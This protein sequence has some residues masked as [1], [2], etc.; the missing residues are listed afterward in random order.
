MNGRVVVLA[1]VATALLKLSAL[2]AQ[3]LKELNKAE[4][5]HGTD[6]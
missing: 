4:Y 5:H 2:D 1:V 3:F 6:T